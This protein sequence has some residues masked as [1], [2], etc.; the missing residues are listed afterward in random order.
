MQPVSNQTKPTWIFPREHGAWAMLI[1]PFLLGIAISG[2]TLYHAFAGIGF[3]MGYLAMYAFLGIVRQ[4]RRMREL[5][6]CFLVYSLGAVCFLLIPFL[7]KPQAF[8]PV[9][10]MVPLLGISVIFIVKKKE[11]HF[12]NDLAGITALTMLLPIAA[13]LGQQVQV[14]TVLLAMGLNIV[15]FTG[16][17]F[18][19]KSMIRE[20]TNQSFRMIGI[21][22]HVCVLLTALLF[23]STTLLAL[24]FI[25]STIKMLSVIRI[26]QLKPI[27]VGI[28]EIVNA[29]WFVVGAFWIL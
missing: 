25:P 6:L 29:V 27:A 19:V 2:H 26:Q 17:V 10:A 13:S 18:Y 14:S 24:L 8:L 4:P 1:M 3:F 5:L 28:T 16:S 7:Y 23:Q 11:R 21:A 15:Y 22:Y 12:G 9:L 20:R